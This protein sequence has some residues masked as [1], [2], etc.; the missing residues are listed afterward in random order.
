MLLFGGSSINGAGKDNKGMHYSLS[1]GDLNS[2]AIKPINLPGMVKNYPA[3]K[4]M[5]GAVFVAQL[6]HQLKLGSEDALWAY[7][8]QHGDLSSY[9]LASFNIPFRMAMGAAYM[10]E[11]VRGQKGKSFVYKII[12]DGA[13]QG[14]NG[15]QAGGNAFTGT[16]TIGQSPDFAAPLVA[17]VKAKDSLVS[18]VWKGKL[19]RDIPYFAA[20]YRQSGDRGEF[21]KLP[22]R[23]LAKRKGDSATFLFTE[24]VNGN[25]AYRYFIRPADLLDNPGAFNSDTASLVA[26]NFNRLPLVSQL[27]AVDTLSGILLSWQPLAVNPLITGVEIQRSRDPRGDYV[28]ID[29]VSA[30]SHAYMDKRLLPHIAYY[31]RVCVLHAGKQLQSERFYASVSTEEQKTSHIPDAPYGIRVQTGPKGVQVSWQPVSDPDLYAYYVYR[32]TSL[33]AKMQVISPALTDT[34]FTDTASNLSSRASYVYSV[35]AVSN[36]NKESVFSEKVA[37]HLARGRERPLT[38]GGIRLIPRGNQLL[39]EWED[40]KRNDPGTLGY[41]L[42]KCKAGQH[43]LQYDVN[44]P[45]SVEATRLGLQLVVGGVITVPYFEDSVA[46]NGDR[47]EY[48]VSAIDRF[49]VESGLS[50]GTTSAPFSVQQARGPVQ[51]F[52]RPVKEG[53]SLQWEQADPAG[54]KGF[55][56]YRRAITEKIARKIATVAGAVNQYTDKQTPAGTLYVYSIRAVTAGGETDPSDERTVR[57]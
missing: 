27:K 11:E 33:A 6:Q 55:A 53:V 17:Q 22:A 44:K 40:T 47:Y 52:A 54:V 42:Y 12:V 30:L 56:I 21:Y 34:S 16:V 20:V 37:A 35:K 39:V 45:A 38:P 18:I 2:N 13:G 28:I 19:R 10:D 51:V 24:K 36:A 23:I 5:V 41:I 57:K 1:R 46:R 8:Q 7:L 9:A 4:K 25:S 15:G 14:G 32:G 29:T 48:L 43:P 50:P 31:Y 49:G 26:A 3:F